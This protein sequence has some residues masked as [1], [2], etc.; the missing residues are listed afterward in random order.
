M[1][2]A[3]PNTTPSAPPLVKNVNLKTASTTTKLKILS[4]RRNKQWI[5]IFLFVGIAG[6]F[7]YLFYTNARDV[8]NAYMNYKSHINDKQIAQST[9]KDDSRQPINDDEIYDNAPLKEKIEIGVDNIT[10]TKNIDN[11][12]KTYKDYND[13][14]KKERPTV[15][16]Y[17]DEKILAA[18]NDDY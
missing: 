12:K 17:V 14:L 6:F 18:E 9:S 5:M 10:I 2:K 4:S 11:I 15:Q 7:G 3:M 16:D 1:C 13:L 8:Y